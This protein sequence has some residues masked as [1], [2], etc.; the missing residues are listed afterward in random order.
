MLV[1]ALVTPEGRTCVLACSPEDLDGLAAGK[2][3]K[4]ELRTFGV[5][6][7]D[8]DR[9]LLV[10]R[11]GPELRAW[12]EGRA[13]PKEYARVDCL[14]Q[15]TIRELAEGGHVLLPRGRDGIET[16]VVGRESMVCVHRALEAEGR[17]WPAVAAG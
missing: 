7:R 13:A 11:D 2:P 6:G 5:E 10:C 3:L 8:A 16:L 4:F 15:Q 12:R 17:R 9:F 14:T 1:T